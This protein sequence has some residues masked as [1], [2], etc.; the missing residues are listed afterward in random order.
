MDKEFLKRLGKCF[1]LCA[2]Y[3]IDNK[4]AS[5][6]HGIITNPFDAGNFRQVAHAWVEDSERVIDL[7]V[8]NNLPK[9]A[10]YALFKAT[11]VRTY[12]REEAATEMLK[13]RHYGPW[14]KE[15]TRDQDIPIENNTPLTN[16]GSF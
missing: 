13:H 7:V 12:S 14:T 11:A 1:S 6:V 16:V 10:Y 2:E 9:D 4:G 5:L 8:G 3:V 15:L